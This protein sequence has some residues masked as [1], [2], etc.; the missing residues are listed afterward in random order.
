MTSAI[1][2]GTPVRGERLSRFMPKNATVLL[3]TALPGQI[4]DAARISVSASRW[5][6]LW[7]TETAAG[8]WG[9][10]TFPRGQTIVTARSTPSFACRPGS[11][12]AR[13]AYT[14][15]ALVLAHGT[16]MAPRTCGIVYAV[17]ALT[18]PGL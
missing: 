8:G 18:D 6:V 13:T 15:P 5:Q 9:L 11:V 12:S 16:F 10:S 4:A 14:M 2:L 7:R 3:P 17:R 1:T